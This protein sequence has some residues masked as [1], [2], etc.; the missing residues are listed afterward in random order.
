MAEIIALSF[1]FEA[2]RIFSIHH[3]T[4]KDFIVGDVLVCKTEQIL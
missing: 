2:S 1:N 3:P 4:S